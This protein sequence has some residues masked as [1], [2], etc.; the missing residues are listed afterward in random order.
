MKRS[1]DLSDIFIAEGLNDSIQKQM[2]SFVTKA[3]RSVIER[4]SGNI[5][6]LGTALAKGQWGNRIRYTYE[7][8]KNLTSRMVT[9]EAVIKLSF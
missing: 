3:S 5:E 4:A 7:I 9:L 8:P 1:E 6:V 2:K